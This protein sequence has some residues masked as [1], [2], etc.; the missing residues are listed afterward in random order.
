MKRAEIKK[1]ECENAELKGQLAYEKARLA[2]Y[3]ETLGKL[4]DELSQI[5][6]SYAILQNAFDEINQD[7][8]L[9]NSTIIDILGI[10]ARTK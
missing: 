3:L 7:F 1:M 10:K 8:G 4:Q 5:K 2:H 6:K 9:L